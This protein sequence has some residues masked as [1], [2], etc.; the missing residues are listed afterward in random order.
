MRYWTWKRIVKPGDR[1]SLSF[2]VPEVKDLLQDSLYIWDS[3]FDWTCVKYFFVKDN[4]LIIDNNI[5]IALWVEYMGKPEALEYLRTNTNMEEIEPWKF[6]VS[7]EC[8][9]ID[10]HYPAIYLLID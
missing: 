4:D 8:E 6:V 9:M 5:E 3:A 2:Y 7:E 10:I 1:K